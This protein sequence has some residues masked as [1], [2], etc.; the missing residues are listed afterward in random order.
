MLHDAIL[1][2][3]Y[4]SNSP[5]LQAVYH[6]HLLYYQVAKG[7]AHRKMCR[8]RTC[9]RGEHTIWRPLKR[10]LQTRRGDSCGNR[11]KR[12]SSNVTWPRR[13]LP[14]EDLYLSGEFTVISPRLRIPIDSSIGF[15]R[16]CIT[17][18]RVAKKGKRCSQSFGDAEKVRF[19]NPNLPKIGRLAA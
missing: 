2:C 19:R 10:R 9:R 1:P 6:C 4:T 8:R 18:S 17:G 7:T 5:C 15:V 13:T 14:A 12:T 3:H 16:S 11:G